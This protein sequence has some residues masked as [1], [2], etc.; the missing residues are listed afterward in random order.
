MAAAVVERDGIG[1]TPL[2]RAAMCAQ[3]EG[4]AAIGTRLLLAAGADAAGK[5]RH[6]STALH[7]AVIQG[8]DDP[9]LAGALMGA[10]CDPAAEQ[11]G[12]GSAPLE[13]AKENNKPRMAA[14]LQAVAGEKEATLAPY[15][16]EAATLVQLV[17]DLGL[18]RGL[19]AV[20]SA[21]LPLAVRALEP[22]YDDML[23]R[24]TAA[25]AKI[26]RPV[27]EAADALGRG[28]KEMPEGTYVCVAGRG[29]GAYV[30]FGK[31]TFGANEHTIRFADGETAVVNLKEAEWSVKEAEMDAMHPPQSTAFKRAA[32]VPVLRRL[33]EEH[34]LGLGLAVIAAPTDLH[35]SAEGRVEDLA[36]GV[37]AK[38]A[39]GQREAGT[40]HPRTHPWWAPFA[41][42]PGRVF[43]WQR[44][45]RGTR[46]TRHWTARRCARCRRARRR[47]ARG[48]SSRRAPTPRPATATRGR[49][50]TA[51]RSSAPT[52]RPSR[53]C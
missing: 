53:G 25:V 27:E 15:R 28:D 4:A 41:P 39:A 40:Q 29:R 18:E 49:R 24:S 46:C 1:L 9:A 47:T 6:E 42:H 34:G 10:G 3:P 8:P 17:A 23:A 7:M 35:K 11:A 5:N 50:C 51:S 12:G 32:E 26:M 38:E 20:A 16:A 44:W 43:W 14:L 31:K 2:D 52:T 30:K 33:V 13:L 45:R 37:L 48:C 36:K 21:E 22:Q 19:A